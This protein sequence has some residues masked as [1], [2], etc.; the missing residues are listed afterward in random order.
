MITAHDRRTLR[1]L[2][3]R[4]AELSSLPIMA[5]R[6]EMWMRHNSLER[7][8]PMILKDTHTC[9]GHPERFTRWTAIARELAEN[10]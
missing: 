10:S 9:E 7:V 4:V 1:N 2:A 3:R 5:E 6:R 8:R